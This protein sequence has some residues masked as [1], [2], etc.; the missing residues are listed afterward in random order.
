VTLEHSRALLLA[1]GVT[2]MGSSALEHRLE[3][4]LTVVSL[5]PE[6]PWVPLTAKVLLTTLRRLPGRLHLDPTGLPPPLVDQLV[7]TVAAIDPER[8][9]TADRRAPADPTVRLHIGADAP[10]GWIRIIPE[11]YGAHIIG[12]GRASIRIHR[13]ANPLGAIYTAALGAAEA[14][15]HTAEVLPTRRVIYRHLRF[16][17]VSLS[18]DLHRAPELPGDLQLNLTL[19]GLGA[20]G[21]ATALILGELQAT[22]VLVL[23]D[24]ERYDSEN[25]GTYSLGGDH[26]GK[27]RPWKV[28][29]AANALP[30]YDVVPIRC[31][32][33]QHRTTL[34]QQ[35][36][37][38]PR[39]VLAGLDTIEASH[40]T[41]RLWPDRLIDAATGDTMLGLHDVV[42]NGPCLM[43]FLPLPSS[44]PST[45]ERLALKTGLRVER[46]ARG[47]EPLSEAELAELGTEQRERLLP[48]LGK[49]KCGLANALGLTAATADGYQPSVPFISQQA[50]C[51][52]VGACSA[53]SC[54]CP[55]ARISSST[56]GWSD[57]GEQPRSGA[58]LLPPAT[59]RPE[60]QPSNA[61]AH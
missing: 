8:S 38:W 51:L 15:K 30:D 26:E 29:L 43:C 40:E 60:R 53:R 23:V 54:G 31:D 6:L 42:G 33:E 45:L 5:D 32:V 34:E 39:T 7:A 50:A 20:V 41:Q 44:G 57:P 12:S 52:G 56:T 47:A 48:H 35:G 14:F 36:G 22:G 19:V 4:A 27:E 3:G 28:D 59:A 24:P 21:T 46:L 18:T 25:R 49:P 13:P 16:C 1:G 2:D 58:R 61:F 10:Y 55:A 37:P 9:I 17:P 11:G